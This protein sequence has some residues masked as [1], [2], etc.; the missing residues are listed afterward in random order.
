[1][2]TNLYY[3]LHTCVGIRRVKGLKACLWVSGVRG[4]P[5]LPLCNIEGRSTKL[6]KVPLLPNK[7]S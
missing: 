1:M 4:F 3:H 6:N 2:T 7:F 5:I